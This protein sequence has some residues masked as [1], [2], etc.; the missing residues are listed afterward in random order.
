MPY[1]M[2]GDYY[3]GDYYQAGGLFGTLGKVIKKVAGT[4]LSVVPG[5]SV[6]RALAGPLVS[7][8]AG[9]SS[10]AR[11]LYLP[12]GPGTTMSIP[13][14]GVTGIA[15]RF[16]EGGHPGYGRYTKDGRFTERRRPR[17]QVTNTRA[18]KRAGRRVRG[19]LRIARSLGALPITSG[20]GKKLFKRKRKG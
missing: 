4:A 7:S 12:P 20:K 18:L 1:Y 10:P 9:G 11:G 19:F 13:E 17:M 3:Q 5:G 16:F 6:V 15:H 8:F 2:A 14:P